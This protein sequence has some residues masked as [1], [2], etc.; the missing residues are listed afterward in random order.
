MRAL[1]LLGLVAA[2]GGPGAAAPGRDA[3]QGTVSLG[4]DR[5]RLALV[6]REGDGRGAVAVAVSTDGLA[7]GRG[8]TPGVALAALVEAR[9]GARGTE[10]VAVGGWGGWRLEAPVTSPADGAALVDAIRAAMQGPIAADEP[11]LATAMHKLEL[12]GHRR[13]PDTALAPV[14]E[15]TGEAWSGGDASPPTVAELEA[16]RAAAHGVTRVAF[17]TTGDAAL[18]SAVVA[19]LSRGPGWPA[20]APEVQPSWPAAD[21]PASTYDASGEL[22]AGG[23]RIVVTA[24]TATPERA[25]GSAAWL[26]DARGPLATRLSGLDAPARVSSVVATAHPW[27]GCVAV[28]IDMAPH[29]LQ[30]DAPRRV[31]IAAALARQETTVE[32]ADRPEG[33]LDAPSHA[34]AADARDAA[35]EAAWW[36]LAGRHAGPEDLRVSSVVGLAAPRDPAAGGGTASDPLRSEIDR[37]T[38]AW[39]SPVVE[40]RTRIERGQG[41]AWLLLASPCGTVAEGPDAGSGAVATLAAASGAEERRGDAQVEPFV[42]ADGLGMLVHGTTHPGESPAAA[43]RRLADLV[44]RAFAADNLDGAAVDRERASLLA[45]ASDVDARA[46]AAAATALTGGHPSWLTPLGTREG[47]ASLSRDDV[48]ARVSALRAGPLRVAV[49]ADRDQDEADAAVR[50]VDRWIARR[51][52]ESRTCPAGV[53]PHA[54][55]G[56]YAVELPPGARAQA[57]LLVP[58]PPQDREAWLDAT[59]L[60]GTLDGPTGLLARALTGNA[61]HALATSWDVSVLGSPATPALALRIGAEDASLDAAVAQTRA[62]LDRLRQGA[63]R[64]EDRARAAASQGRD[65]LRDGMDPRARILALWRAEAPAVTPTLDALRTFA[66]STLRDDALVIAAARAPRATRAADPREPARKGR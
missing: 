64:D 20:G 40:A 3:R 16:W 43:A 23:A 37:A 35:E 7:P 49:L 19:A 4:A 53:V 34:N 18:G 24:R 29:D 14:A 28:S 8:A 25:V 38:L 44:A 65:A 41:E 11:A 33:V 2:C 27:G 66:A 63:L 45:R 1:L 30:R 17:A 26:G 55:A 21:A 36:A 62:L 22:T 5:P 50:A 58:L 60:A 42:A 57:L 31:A 39:H 13:L 15:C 59:G 54:R 47:L 48:M 52:G 46:L 10:A 9:L 6:T 32:L 51:P 12:L 61:D 56:T